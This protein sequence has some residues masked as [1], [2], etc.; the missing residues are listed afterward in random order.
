MAGAM[1]LPTPQDPWR[2]TRVRLP[3]RHHT[4]Q[5]LQCQRLAGRRRRASCFLGA[6]SCANACGCGG[7]GRAELERL[8]LRV[9]AGE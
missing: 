9:G 3:S 6:E 8:L 2:R 7:R 4:P 5:P 1:Q